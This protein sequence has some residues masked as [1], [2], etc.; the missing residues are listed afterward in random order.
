[1][2][3]EANDG[4][5]KDC[6]PEIYGSKEHGNLVDEVW[7]WEERVYHNPKHHDDRRPNNDNISHDSPAEK[8]IRTRD[9]RQT[10]KSTH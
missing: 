2:H 4:G 7:A 6:C 10:N 1:M 5:Q 8:N 9:Q 3:T